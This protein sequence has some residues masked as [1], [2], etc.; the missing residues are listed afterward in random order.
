M[1]KLNYELALRESDGIEVAL[2][3]DGVEDRVLLDVR[4]S[5]TGES[6]ICD[7]DRADALDA[8]RHPFAYAARQQRADAIFGG[9]ASRER[10]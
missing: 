9:C 6:F 10:S 7:V 3:W 8:F 5:R 2:L 4:D 1:K